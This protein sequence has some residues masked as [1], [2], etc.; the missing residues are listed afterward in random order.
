[1]H[2]YIVFFNSV[3]IHKT[4]LFASFQL[5]LVALTQDEDEVIMGVDRMDFA[6]QEAMDDITSEEDEGGWVMGGARRKRRH[7]NQPR[8][9]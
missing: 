2:G 4:P 6:A 7:R 5:N 1:M 9:T 3:D 8:S